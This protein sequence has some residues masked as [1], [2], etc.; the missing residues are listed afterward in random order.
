MQK[1]VSER[2]LY[3][4]VAMF[5]QKQYV[6]RLKLIRATAEMSKVFAEHEVSDF[7]SPLLT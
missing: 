4:N 5:L 3:H 1:I 7:C 6:K 2:G